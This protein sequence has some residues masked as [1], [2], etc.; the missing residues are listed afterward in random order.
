MNNRAAWTAHVEKQQP[1]APRTAPARTMALGRMKAGEMNRTETKFSLHLEARKQAG[2]V[3]WWGFERFTFKLADDVRLTPDFTALMA[4]GLL[5]CF[6]VKGTTTKN[7]KA[8]PVKAPYMLDDARI[9][10]KVAAEQIPVVFKI[11]YLVAGEWREEE[12]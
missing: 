1:A 4:D 7:L 3:I 11:A 6:E 5:V 2:E 9:K 8:G 12:V 10:L